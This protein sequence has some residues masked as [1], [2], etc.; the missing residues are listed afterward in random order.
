M[1]KVHNITPNDRLLKMY[2]I[3]EAVVIPKEKIVFTSIINYQKSMCK[4]SI[5]LRHA[6]QIKTRKFNL[7]AISEHF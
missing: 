3:A 1:E 7:S 5:A 4:R 2:E 6:G